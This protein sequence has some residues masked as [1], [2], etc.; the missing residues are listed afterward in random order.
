MSDQSPFSNWPNLDN[1]EREKEPARI[2][3]GSTSPKD[4]AMA[5]NNAL[6]NFL[7]GSPL[8]VTIKLIFMSLVVGALLMWL[9]L[10]P[11]DILL[12]VRNFIDSIYNMGFDAVRALAEYVVAGAVIVV[13]VWFILRLMNS[14]NRR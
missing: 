14:G 1:R 4:E 10:R 13:P 3:P 6:E 7:G 5:P 9:N 8:N 11:H 12:A 2:L